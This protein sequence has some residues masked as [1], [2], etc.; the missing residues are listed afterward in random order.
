[1]PTG[2]YQ[3][4]PEMFR[5]CAIGCGCGK[6]QPFSSVRRAKLSAK[7][8]ARSDEYWAQVSERL[9]GTKLSEETKAKIS[10]AHFGKTLTEEHK[11][12]IGSA[13]IGR[14][15]G[16]KTRLK[17]S[18]SLNGRSPS[19]PASH[20]RQDYFSK[21]GLTVTMRSIYELMFAEFLDQIGAWWIYEPESF[22]LEDGRGYTP[23]FLVIWPEGTWEYSEIKG[24][25]K[26]FSKKNLEKFESF[27]K[28]KPAKLYCSE[29]IEQLSKRN[30]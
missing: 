28:V 29:D 16:L 13:L 19:T 4:K 7:A 26:S 3:R 30:I 8:S 25:S 1:M 10:A 24:K 12:K 11:A 21:A 14:K 18:A 9:T 20:Q 5:T 17:L 2:V 15:C 23:D 27:S 6:H 22:I